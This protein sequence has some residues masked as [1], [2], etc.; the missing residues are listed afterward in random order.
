MLFRCL[1]LGI[2]VRPNRRNHKRAGVEPRRGHGHLA[3]V[4]IQ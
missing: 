2:A 3:T 1:P 4:C